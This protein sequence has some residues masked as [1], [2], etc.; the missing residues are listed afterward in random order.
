MGRKFGLGLFE[1]GLQVDRTDRRI[2]GV[3]VVPGSRGEVAER[4]R[5]LAA[6]VFDHRSAALG[7]DD[8]AC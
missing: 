1:G 6:G 4:D 2:P 7:D 5:L 8:L 3:E